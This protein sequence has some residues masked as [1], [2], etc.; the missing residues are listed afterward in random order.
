[1]IEASPVLFLVSEVWI[2]SCNAAGDTNTKSALTKLGVH[3]SIAGG[4]L[5]VTTEASYAAP[6]HSLCASV[7]IVHFP[8]IV[9]GES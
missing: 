5:G 8:F 3:D 4:L 7:T 6:A 2:T 1:M 9:L